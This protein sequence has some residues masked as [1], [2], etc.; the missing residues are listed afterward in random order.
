MPNTPSRAE[1][2]RLTAELPADTRDPWGEVLD[3]ANRRLYAV[4]G[5]GYT[6]PLDTDNYPVTEAEHAAIIAEMEG[7]GR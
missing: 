1:T 2:D 4:R 6:G 5:A 3:D 7:A